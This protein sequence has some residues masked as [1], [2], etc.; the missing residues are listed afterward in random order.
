MRTADGLCIEELI[1]C[2]RCVHRTSMQ[3]RNAIFVSVRVLNTRIAPC[4]ERFI[5]IG[6]NH[7]AC[8]VLTPHDR[9]YVMLRAFALTRTFDFQPVNSH[10][11]SISMRFDGSHRSARRLIG[12]CEPHLIS[13][14]WWCFH[15]LGLLLGHVRSFFVPACVFTKSSV[16]ANFLPTLFRTTLI[17]CSI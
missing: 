6:V 1:D 7:S 3:L 10:G 11:P 9:S 16:L 5:Q 8:Y 17:E 2:F 14:L 15:V 13:L 4:V 12:F